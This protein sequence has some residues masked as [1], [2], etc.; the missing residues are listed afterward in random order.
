MTLGDILRVAAA[1]DLAAASKNMGLTYIELT[2]GGNFTIKFSSTLFPEATIECSV[3]DKGQED[4]K[5]Y[6]RT[7]FLSMVFNAAIYGM[8]RKSNKKSKR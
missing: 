8:R 3:P 7:Y 4:E 5:N 6:L 2:S 1:R